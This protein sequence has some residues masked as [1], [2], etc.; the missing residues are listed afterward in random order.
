MLSTTEDALSWY[1]VHTHPKQEDRTAVNLQAWG[2]ETLSPKL[3]VNRCNEFSGQISRVARPLFPSYIFTRFRFNESYHRVRFT[4]GVNSVITFNDQPT[5][6][7]DQIIDLIRARIESNG[8]V[9]TIDDFQAGDEVVINEGRFQ[10]FCGVFER[11]IEDA[12]RVRILL[13]TVSFQAHIVVDKV[14][15]TRLAG[16]NDHGSLND[17]HICSQP[18]N[19]TC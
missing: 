18:H 14:L 13:N 8:F 12:D 10:N 11:E 7:E 2:M 9:K 4:R 17:T 3:R 19:P 1:V 15:V 6:L 16:N 5:P